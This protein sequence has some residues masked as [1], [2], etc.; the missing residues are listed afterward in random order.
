L[1]DLGFDC[2]RA[3]CA[4]RK[5]ALLY[6]VVAISFLLVVDSLGQ[7][8][9]EA[10]PSADTAYEYALGV[11]LGGK[12]S[13]IVDKRVG[14][15]RAILTC[16]DEASRKIVEDAVA[17]VNDAFGYAKIALSVSEKTVLADDA[18]I[19]FVGSK[20]DG[21][22]LVESFGI[23]SPRAFGDGVY[24][25]WW[26]NSQRHHIRRCLIAIN[27]ESPP[28]R[29]TDDLKDL[30]MACMGFQ[31][32]WSSVNYHPN[33]RRRES[34]ETSIFSS[35]GIAVVRF[36]DKQINPGAKAW[37][38][39]NVFKREWPDF[40]SAYWNPTKEQGSGTAEARQ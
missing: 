5:S 39:R 29:K 6:S 18:L 2:P 32:P 1:F 33:A 22:Q 23:S 21:R 19:I 38:M 4:Q 15:I 12:K 3:L 24:Y 31:S 26:D 14:P 40:S 9:T 35:F 30:L 11:V 27:E 7:Q 13:E 10:L 37:E 20:S 28:E 8:G 17:A 25:Y 16:R 36:F 34:Q